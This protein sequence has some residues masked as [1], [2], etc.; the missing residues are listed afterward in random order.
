MM[1]DELQNL[2]NLGKTSVRWLHAVGIHTTADLRRLGAVD[3][4]KAVRRRGFRA[5]KVLLYAIEAA[6][7]D[8]HWND[9]PEDRKQELNE[10][11]CP[12][13]CVRQ[14]IGEI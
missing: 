8:I 2:R 10:K 11:A 12:T 4:Y 5:T 6:L 13:A 1:N 14:I 3:A 9:L 7:L